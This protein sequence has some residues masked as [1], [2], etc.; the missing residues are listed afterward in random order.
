MNAITEE[1]I[2]TLIDLSW[3][4]YKLMYP[5]FPKEYSRK[6]I[7][8]AF[9]RLEKKGIIQ[10]GIMED[11]VCIRLTEFG[12][13]KFREKQERKIQKPNINKKDERWDGKWRVVIFD[14]PEENRRVREALRETL[15]LM[16]F[17]PLQK[18]VWVSKNDYVKELRWWIRDLKLTSFIKIL[19]TKDIG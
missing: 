18:S 17:Y 19:E 10:R 6:S 13:N 12:L 16:E 5:S 15:K 3:H 14:I 7:N 9:G 11:E 1:I 8:K 2:Q 4:P